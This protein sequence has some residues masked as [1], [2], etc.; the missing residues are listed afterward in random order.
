MEKYRLRR[1]FNAAAGRCL[2][3]AVDHGFFNELG[4]LGGIEVLEELH[5]KPFKQVKPRMNTNKHEW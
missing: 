5:K 2:D 3:V 1:L 4:F